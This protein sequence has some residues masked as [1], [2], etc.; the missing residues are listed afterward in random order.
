M[1]GRAQNQRVGACPAAAAHLEALMGEPS[2]L[3]DFRVQSDKTVSRE[4]FCYDWQLAQAHFCKARRGLNWGFG[5]SENLQ[6]VYVL[7]LWFLKNMF[8]AG[9]VFKDPDLKSRTGAERRRL[10]RS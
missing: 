1:S 9:G 6:Q 4:T 7:V 2:G 3:S 10:R 8:L 5:A